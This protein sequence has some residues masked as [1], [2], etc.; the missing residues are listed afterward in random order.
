MECGNEKD[1]SIQGLTEVSGLSLTC[2]ADQGKIVRGA[3]AGKFILIPKRPQ[4]DVTVTMDGI[5]IGT[6]K[7]F[8]K[9]V[10]EPQAIL[11]VNGVEV[12]KEEGAP[13]GVAKYELRIPDETFTTQN[14]ADAGYRITKMVVYTATGPKTVNN[15]T[16]DMAAL[17]IR[18]KST[19]T[20]GS[21]TVVRSTYDP[22]VPDDKP[23]NHKLGDTF[24]VK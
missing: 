24:V 12:K 17:G 1:V 11:K 18:S 20:I 21:V 8:A 4:M 10:P 13:F 3:A 23:V 19:F 2:P 16:I 6:E 22:A 5:N 14:R 9:P 15:N 7:F